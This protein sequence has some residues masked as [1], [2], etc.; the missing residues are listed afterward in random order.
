MKILSPFDSQALSEQ[1]RLQQKHGWDLEQDFSWK[2]GIRDDAYFVPLIENK[3]SFDGASEEQK[4]AISQL[5]GLI[6]NQ[7]ICEMESS[8][9]KLKL[10]AWE[11][12]LKNYPVNPEMFELGE[13]FFDEEKKHAK[14]FEKFQ[15]IF[16]SQ[17]GISPEDLKRILP[18]ALNSNF[19]NAITWNAQKGGAAFWWLVAAVEEVSV[20]VFKTINQHRDQ[21]DPLFY[22][23]HKKHTEE[24]IRHEN[25]AFLMLEIDHCQRQGF[26][27]RVI[28]KTDL[29]LAETVSVPWVITELTKIF[30]VRDYKHK[31][32][33][34]EILSTCLPF[35]EKM[36]RLELF[37]AL[38]K[39][40]PYISWMINP[41]FRKKHHQMLKLTGSLS[42]ART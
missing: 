40:A 19:L 9:P 35:L 32:P 23:L 14:S 30:R 2:T 37:G 41:A 34:F 29:L 6:I 11:K 31:G 15:E 5:L 20:Q 28:K 17:Q 36:D 16:C 25:Y 7:T 10:L 42:W 3:I 38:F 13:I 26:S 27:S 21:T 22:Q 24:E 18:S 39:E 12:K 4:I 8:L 1:V 33:F